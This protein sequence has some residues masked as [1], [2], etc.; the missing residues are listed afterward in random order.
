MEKDLIEGICPWVERKTFLGILSNDSRTL[1]FPSGSSGASIG[2]YD[3]PE[4]HD[5][6]RS[7]RGEQRVSK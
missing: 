6:P 2:L 1:S 7:I 3:S 5:R 4:D